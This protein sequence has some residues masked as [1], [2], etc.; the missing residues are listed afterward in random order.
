MLQALER[1]RIWTDGVGYDTPT[2]GN[3]V[4]PLREQFCQPKGDIHARVSVCVDFETAM[5]TPEPSPVIRAPDTLPTAPRTYFACILCIDS[6]Y[7][8][9]GLQGNRF[10]GDLEHFIRH[11]FNFAICFAIEFRFPK[12]VKVLD[13]YGRFILLCECDDS[14]RCLITPSLGKIPLVPLKFLKRSLGPCASFVCFAP[15]LAPPHTD[16]ALPLHDI[17]AEVKLPQNLALADDRNGC[18]T[19]RANIH[20]DYCLLN[21]RFFNSNFSS[22]VNYEDPALAPSLE[23]ELGKRIA[24]SK[25]GFKPAPA[26][27]LFNWQTSALGTFE[28]SDTNNWVASFGLGEFPASWNVIVDNC[29]GE[30]LSPPAIF[31]DAVH[32]LDEYLALNGK[33]FSSDAVGG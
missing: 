23:A 3:L 10:E 28:G 18:Q 25:Q 5:R 13:G 21:H 22:E 24:L 26:T 1:T 9:A 19:R 31:P 33:L 8:D 12:P 29:M 14:M 27:I 20:S 32:G 30:L 16:V 4:L 15:Q 2:L 7:L 6:G 11:P 17:P